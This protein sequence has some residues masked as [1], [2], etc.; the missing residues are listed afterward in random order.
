MLDLYMVEART[1]LETK[2]QLFKKNQ[3]NLS[4]NIGEHQREIKY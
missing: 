4:E 2:G 1:Q 3:L